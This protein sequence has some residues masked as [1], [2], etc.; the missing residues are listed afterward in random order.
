M[1]FFLYVSLRN[2]KAFGIWTGFGILHLLIYKEFIHEPGF[3][4]AKGSALRPLQNTLLLLLL[5]QVLRWT[6]LKLTK[7]ELVAP[8]KGRTDLFEERQWSVLD[9]VWFLVYFLSVLALDSGL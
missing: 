5:F 8:A 7:T 3:M 2:V 6:F 1:Y 4:L 9:F